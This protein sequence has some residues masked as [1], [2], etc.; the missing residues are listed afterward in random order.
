MIRPATTEA[1][2]ITELQ[3]HGLR[4]ADIHAHSEQGRIL[5]VAETLDVVRGARL[6]RE[7]ADTLQI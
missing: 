6:A 1:T 3:E 5:A 4:E 2:V 7:M